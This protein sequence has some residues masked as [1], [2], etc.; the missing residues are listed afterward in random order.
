MN[1]AR[2]IVAVAVFGVMAANVSWAQQDAGKAVPAPGNDGAL[3]D[4]GDAGRTL[5][6][7]TPK[8]ISD[9]GRPDALPSNDHD[10]GLAGG[11]GGTSQEGGRG[12][13]NP[14][15]AHWTITN[16]P[17]KGA[18]P[19]IDLT[20]PDDGYANLRRRAARRTLITNYAAKGIVAGPLANGGTHHQGSH[21][22]A[23]VGIV[24]NAV[25]VTLPSG[26]GVAGIGVAGIETLHHAPGVVI[27]AETGIA[28]TGAG[29]PRI[30][31]PATHLGSIAAPSGQT[32]G[33]GGASF[34]HIGNGV[35]S[36][37]GPWKNRSGLN[38]TGLRSKR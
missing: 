31:R 27:H 13:A 36:V 26:T 30:F 10:A 8:S 2:M 14:P 21:S 19:R 4:N 24:R 28:D 34:V 38:G 5:G 7:V 18:A 15:T 25:G 6:N 33:I 29:K 35:G 22:S 3:H 11:R 23:G 17:A 37:G 12:D 32:T 1:A 20:R 16:G 9:R